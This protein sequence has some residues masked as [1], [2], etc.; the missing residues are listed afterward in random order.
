MSGSEAPTPSGVPLVAIQRTIGAGHE[1]SGKP[2]Q[3]EVGSIRLGDRT[4]IA[5][6]DGHGSSARADVGARLAV[7]VALTALMRFAS[8]LGDR[9]GHLAEVQSYAEH[10]LRVH[11]TRQWRERVRAHAADDT[12]PLLAY[13]TTLLFALATPDFLLLGQLGDGDVLLGVGEAVSRPLPADPRAFADETPSLCLPEAWQSLRVRALPPPTGDTL[14]LLA[15]DGYSNSYPDD[16]GFD[17]VALDYLRMAREGGLPRLAP[18]LAGF[19]RTVTR[20]GS[21]D[22]IGLALAHW[23]GSP[24]EAPLDRSSSSASPRDDVLE[25]PASG[26]LTEAAEEPPAEDVSG[27]STEAP[28]RST[29]GGGLAS[30]QT[31]SAHPPSSSTATSPTDQP[32]KAP[33]DHEGHRDA[34]ADQD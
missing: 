28:Q 32:A 25:T 3:D 6:A 11:L 27:P 2:C 15:T 29:D 21:G 16:A 17:A 24:D 9:S 1:R 20:Q 31:G 30:A 10:P 19:L 13:G 14:L 7:E 23:P 5:V 8:D 12:V 18:H 4:A 26:G 33:H 34:H 22:D